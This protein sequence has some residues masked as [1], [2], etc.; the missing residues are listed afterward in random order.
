MLQSLQDYSLAFAIPTMLS[1]FLSSLN[2][3][4]TEPFTTS[5]FSCSVLFLTPQH[6]I[7]SGHIWLVLERQGLLKVGQEKVCP[8]SKLAERNMPKWL[9]RPPKPM[10]FGIVSEL[11]FTAHCK[12]KIVSNVNHLKELP[13]SHKHK[14]ASK[15]FFH[16]Q[17]G[18][19]DKKGEISQL[20]Q[21][22][23]KGVG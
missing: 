18:K 19:V 12:C 8:W 16:S 2:L 17:F 20:F 1:I 4:N 6:S 9:A 23:R 14:K 10:P 5:C 13:H 3:S 21:I 15:Q 22:I 7:T 11:K